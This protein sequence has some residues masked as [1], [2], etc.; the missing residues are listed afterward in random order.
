M[1]DID[2]FIRDKSIETPSLEPLLTRYRGA[3]ILTHKHHNQA[4][5]EHPILVTVLDTAHTRRSLPTVIGQSFAVLQV[6]D[7]IQQGKRFCIELSPGNQVWL[8]REMVQ[9][10]YTR[11]RTA[12]RTNQGVYE[13]A[14]TWNDALYWR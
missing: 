4:E 3:P 2:D 13:A 10:T 11:N 5:P 1:I 6:Q 9:V 7:T 8:P 12:D 14:Q